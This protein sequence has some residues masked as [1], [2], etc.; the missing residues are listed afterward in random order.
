MKIRRYSTMLLCLVIAICFTIV[1]GQELETRFGV[2]V[3]KPD[4]NT[5]YPDNRHLF[6]VVYYPSLSNISDKES[7]VKQPL[8]LIKDLGNIDTCEDND[9][10]TVVENKYGFINGSSG[11]CSI[12]DRTR[13]LEKYQAKGLIGDRVFSEEYNSSEYDISIQLFSLVDVNA[14]VRDRIESFQAKYSDGYFYVYKKGTIDKRFD[15][16]MALVFCMAVFTVMVGSFWSGYAKQNLRL[17]LK[18]REKDGESGEDDDEKMIKSPW[19]VL[20]WVLSVC[21]LLVLMYFFYDILVY[22]LIAIFTIGSSCAMY[23]CL[24]YPVMTLYKKSCLPSI[25]LPRCNLYL[26]IINME[27]P[28]FLLLLCSIATSVTWFVFRKTDW[29]WGLQAFLGIIFCIYILKMF[30]LPN[31]KICTILFC[32]FII[33]DIFFVFITPLF[34]PD[35]K[36]IMLQVATGFGKSDEVAKGSDEPMPMLFKVPK[37]FTDPTRVCFN[38]SYSILGF[39]DILL[40]GLLMS[41]VHSYDLLT[42][43]KYKLYWVITTIGYILG[44][45]ATHISLILM[46]QG[47][48][49]LLYLL[50]LTLIPTILVAWYRGDLAP[51]WHGD[52]SDAA[53][54]TKTEA[55][56]TQRDNDVELSSDNS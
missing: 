21:T 41:Y 51:M 10:L 20:F 39:G 9:E 26:C 17:R 28:Q 18:E 2:M 35:G 53:T 15:E 16:T 44:L 50:P 1:Q 56:G 24:E 48:P 34:T 4:K 11:N 29:S 6:C 49:A 3:V 52:N 12:V 30:R 25:R 19:F 43:N 33:Y 14:D 54:E 27:L 37:L 22:F 23:A 8:S 31:L 5:D 40:P 38:D 45:V 55:A 42:G 32:F 7:A 46:D 47:Q 36:S 13:R